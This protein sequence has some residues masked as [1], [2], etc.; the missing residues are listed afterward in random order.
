MVAAVALSG[1]RELTKRHW[2]QSLQNGRSATSAVRR[3]VTTASA[4]ADARAALA[5]DAQRSADGGPLP[6]VDGKTPERQAVDLIARGA[7]GEAAVF[8]DRLARW[9]GV[10]AF[11][12]AARIAQRKARLSK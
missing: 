2:K 1:V 11:R 3:T 6:T 12:E 4:S 7:Y 5:H 10:P 8:Y 9:R